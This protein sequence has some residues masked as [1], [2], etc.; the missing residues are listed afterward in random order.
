M[1]V[2]LRDY[3]T[4]LLNRTRDELKRLVGD[5]LPPSVCVVAPTGAGKTVLFVKMA[6]DLASLGKSTLILSHR[7]ELIKQISRA[8]SEQSVPHGII[9]PKQPQTNDLV[10]VASVNT[11]IRRLGSMTKPRLLVID[12]AHHAN[13]KTWEVIIE[14]CRDV[15]RIVGVTATPQRLDGKGLDDKFTSLIIGPSIK[16]LT[17]ELNPASGMTFLSPPRVYAPPQVVDLSKVKSSFGDFKKNELVEAVDKATV[18]GDAVQHYIKLGRGMP[19]VAFCV[20]VAH[21]EH[22]AEQFNLAGIKA[23]SVDGEMAD[24]RRADVLKSLEDGRIQVLTSCELISEG[25]DLP[26]IGCAILLRPTQSLSMY[27]QQVGR[28][29]RP[30]AGKECAIILDHVGNVQR[31]GMPDDDREWTLEGETKES[32]KKKEQ[33]L[34]IK[35]CPEC[36]AAYPPA[37]E[38]PVCG[39]KSSKEDEITVDEDTE[40]IAVTADMIKKQASQD[41]RKEEGKARRLVDLIKIEKERGYKPGW[42]EGRFRYRLKARGWTEDHINRMVAIEKKFIRD[43]Q[44]TE[45]A[46]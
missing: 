24:D 15:S 37:P 35:T 19:A 22:V 7:Q 23:A 9:A 5:G 4:D 6:A 21:A 26:K 14:W 33:Q 3:Q 1:P 12:E 17:T 8:L 16:W 11:A 2:K 13:A 41:R 20:S 43:T 44:Q 25:F 30:F 38:C 29:L 42:A 39:F 32:K 10:Q 40:L 28:A 34:S 46:S 27:L 45:A 31:H 18:T 36:F